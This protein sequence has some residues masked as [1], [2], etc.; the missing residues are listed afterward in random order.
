MGKE[1]KGMLEKAVGEFVDYVNEGLNLAFDPDEDVAVNQ[2]ESGSDDDGNEPKRGKPRDTFQAD[3]PKKAKGKATREPE[4]PEADDG[5]DGDDGDDE[6]EPE[7]KPK[8][9][10]RKATGK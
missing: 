7:P 1:K 10:K 6:P 4:P 8:P 2:Q 3:T 9:K 5:D